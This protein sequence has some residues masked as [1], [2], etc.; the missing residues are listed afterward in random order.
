AATAAGSFAITGARVFD[1]QTMRTEQTVVVRDGLIDS[2]VSGAAPADLPVVDASGQTLLPGFLDTHTHTFGD[3]QRDAVRFG[4]TTLLDMFTDPRLLDTT[5]QMREDLQ[6]ADRAD[7]FSAGMLATVAGGHGT[8]YGLGVEV[9]TG[10]EDAPG[11]V[12]RRKAEGSDWIKL[13][14]I[15]TN[16]RTPS[17]DLA[18]ATAVIE[19]AHAEG[20]LAVAHISEFAAASELLDAGI[21]GLVHIFYDEL[22]TEN[23]LAR[24]RARENFFVIPTLAITSTID[25]NRP[26]LELLEDTSIAPYLSGNQD[27]MLRQSF[28]VT[29]SRGW[30]DIARANIKALYDAGI[31]ILAGSDAPN[32]S[33]AHG[34]T[35]HQEMRWLVEAG[36][37]P[38]DVLRG[39]TGLPA[40]LFGVPDR[41]IIKPGARADLVLVTGNPAEDI[42][43]TARIAAIWRNGQPVA[44]NVATKT[45]ERPVAN[46]LLGQFE[47][48]SEAGDGYVLA[49]TSDDMMGGNSTVELTAVTPGASG[50]AG[51]LSVKADVRAGFIAPW[52]G[53]FFA[54]SD[55]RGPVSAA[56]FTSLSFDVRGTPARYRVMLF[57]SD[58][59]GAPPT[60]EFDV[61]TDWTTVSLTLAD[62][63][64]F[65]PADFV[66][67]AIVTPMVPGEY[68]YAV[69]NIEL[70][71]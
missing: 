56:P 36:V 39:A 44:R 58:M 43:A 62:A 45:G 54:A 63:A 19:A 3:V 37:D 4:V 42:A 32:P 27:A 70:L 59:L 30:T 48:T 71:Q 68:S 23:F 16:R 26:G 31:P 64:G 65:T 10:P 13:V 50:S 51:A 35:L 20:L 22:V 67:L 21:D 6:T 33:T 15:P 41:G 14:Y 60:L 34:A 40:E 8:Q 69:D 47:S 66:G 7:L 18:T 11:W 53:A 12:Q 49:T 28:G 61:T 55:E 2:I 46:A 5:L 25:G 17:L 38:M 57:S 52:A 9:L 1:G 24:A 29:R